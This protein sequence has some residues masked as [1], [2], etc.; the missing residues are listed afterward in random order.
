MARVAK[1][2]FKLIPPDN[3]SNPLFVL[4]FLSADNVNKLHALL[5]LI[6]GARGTSSE[7]SQSTS[8]DK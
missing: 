7:Q 8:L 3:D 2:M 1:K 5:R 4:A 6:I